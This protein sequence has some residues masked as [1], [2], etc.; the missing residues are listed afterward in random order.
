MPRHATSVVKHFGHLAE[1]LVAAGPLA[2]LAERERAH[3]AVTS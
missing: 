1:E 3:V 2:E